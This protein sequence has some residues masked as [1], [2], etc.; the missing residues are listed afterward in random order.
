MQPRFAGALAVLA[1]TAEA[2]SDE[3][4]IE[5]VVGLLQDLK[6]Q[7]KAEFQAEEVTF[8][9]FTRWCRNSQKTL[10]KAIGEGK[11][12]VETLESTVASK[13]KEEEVL[14]EEIKK[15]EEE[16]A[17]YEA[18]A[19]AAE[20]ERKA[21]A[22]LYDQADKDFADTITAIDDAIA[23]LEGAKGGALV[24][25]ALR[26]VAKL[27]LVLEQLSKEQIQAIVNKD[28]PAVM[29]DKE[30]HVKKYN[31]KSGNVIELLKELKLKFKDDRVAATTEETNALNSYSLA[32][33][34]RDAAH[35]AASEAKGEKEVLKGEAQ[36]ALAAAKAD[37]E[38]VT[39]DLEA[40]DTTLS[41]TKR[42]CDVKSSEWKERSAVREN[43]QAAMA[44]AIEIL[45][46]VAGVRT[47]APS[48]PTLPARPAEADAAGFLQAVDS[49]VAKVGK[50]RAAGLV[51]T[52]AADPKEKAV[53]LLRSE[54]Q[55]VHSKALARF[56][57]QLSQHLGGP[58]DDINDMI[59]KMI[60]RLMAEQK[61]EDDHKN[62]CDLEMGKTNSTIDAKTEKIESLNLKIEEGKASSAELA[63]QI[64]DASDMIAKL[65]AHIAEATEIR[66]I[67]KSE[68]EKA[69]S[70]AKTAQAALAKATAVI[71]AH[72]KQSGMIAKE[73]FE[74]LVQQPV[75]L[76]EQPSTWDAGYTGVADPKSQPEG[77]I[78]ILEKISADFAQMEADT[79]AQE[80]MDQKAYD[81]EVKSSE[82]ERTHRSKEAEMKEAE[83]KRTDDKAASNQAALKGVKE[84]LGAAEQY[85]KELGPPCMEGDATY[86]ARKADRD[87]ELS[88]LKEAQV[89]LQD[90]FKGEGGASAAFLA[91]VRKRS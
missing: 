61:D 6:E 65:Q 17:E 46:K 77:I 91:P 82:V 59:Q 85:Y 53:A 56:A 15:L 25:T 78:T 86:E 10:E 24:Q 14:T 19:T 76:S 69:I 5:K 33:Q 50:A 7:V 27:P 66:Q 30:K 13:T 47:E 20:E 90:A 80:E 79:K 18:A 87:R 4:P 3:H 72:Y 39:A 84:E 54:A 81:E 26:S 67:G 52:S 34:A 37:L 71:E 70:D 38:T 73:S 41:D 51:Q 40:D 8:S 36:E 21:Q 64:A 23:A 42:D 2:G 9:K 48:N 44:K 74:A 35:T 11:A 43:E 83:K 31:F 12:K 16:I 49:Y 57:E 22:D 68:N 89:I 45:A 29:G 55:A 62:W 58:F 1:Y 75:E 32:K 28:D 88:A 63:A 60:F